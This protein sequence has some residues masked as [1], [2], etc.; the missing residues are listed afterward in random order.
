[1]LAGWAG[2]VTAMLHMEG[3]NSFRVKPRT[4][5]ELLVSAK[6]QIPPAAHT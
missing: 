2:L 5:I 6:A 3:K 1:M 4:Q